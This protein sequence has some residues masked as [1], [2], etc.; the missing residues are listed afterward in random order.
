MRQYFESQIATNRRATE[1]SL[2]MFKNKHYTSGRE[3]KA[4][5]LVLFAFTANE[6]ADNNIMRT[7]ISLHEDEI[8]NYETLPDL[9]DNVFPT[10]RLKS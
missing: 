3:I 9:S 4:G 2:S 7:M 5:D 1:E 10:I 6:T 8:D